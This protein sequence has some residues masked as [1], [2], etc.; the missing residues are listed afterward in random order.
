[1]SEKYQIIKVANGESEVIDYASD[2]QEAQF[3]ATEY[4]KDYG[5]KVSVKARLNPDY[6]EN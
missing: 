3:Y 6:Q 4:Q 5:A 2:Y 1:M